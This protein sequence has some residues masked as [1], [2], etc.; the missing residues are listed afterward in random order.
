MV[1]QFATSAGGSIAIASEPGTG[2]VASLRL[3][4]VA[5]DRRSQPEGQQ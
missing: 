3:P 4:A 2:T 5:Q 1:E